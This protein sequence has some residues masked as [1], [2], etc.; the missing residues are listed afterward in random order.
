M[1]TAD[2]W[3]KIVV[4]CLESFGGFLLL[5][6]TVQIPQQGVAPRP[7]AGHCLP[8]PGTT[9]SSCQREGA[10]PRATL[11]WHSAAA[12]PAWHTLHGSPKPGYPLP[13]GNNIPTCTKP[14]APHP[15]PLHCDRPGTPPRLCVSPTMREAPLT[16]AIN[17]RHNTQS[18]D[19]HLV[20]ICC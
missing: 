20:K 13:P 17:L 18:S 14:L 19:T 9:Y 3:Y 12:S 4:T 10:P 1:T 11:A 5:D 16:S 15:R 6:S 7:P 2:S 8:L